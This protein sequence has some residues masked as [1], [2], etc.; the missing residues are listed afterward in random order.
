M[1]RAIPVSSMTNMQTSE[2]PVP[3]FQATP[4]AEEKRPE[5]EKKLEGTLNVL[6]LFD[7]FFF[8]FFFFLNF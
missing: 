3:T 8:F 4:K 1:L 7:F 5:T 2:M 6:E